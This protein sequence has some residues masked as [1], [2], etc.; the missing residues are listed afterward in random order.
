[1]RAMVEARPGAASMICDSIPTSSSFSATHSAAG[2][3]AWVGF[4]VLM[5]IRSASRSATSPWA[6]IVFSER[7]LIPR[8]YQPPELRWCQRRRRRPLS[9][10]TT[11]TATAQTTQSSIRIAG[12]FLGT[13]PLTKTSVPFDFVGTPGLDDDPG[14]VDVEVGAGWLP[15][16]AE[17]E[18]FEESGGVGGYGRVDVPVAD[19][20]DV[21]CVTSEIPGVLGVIGVWG[22]ED[23][24]TLGAW[25]VETGRSTSMR[26]TPE[27]TEMCRPGAVLGGR[28]DDAAAVGLGVGLRAVGRA[29]A[30]AENQKAANRVRR[31]V[32]VTVAI[33]RERA[34]LIG[35]APPTMTPSPRPLLRVAGGGPAKYTAVHTQPT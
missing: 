27:L 14:P 16:G 13:N 1:M 20:R 33:T 11:A 17:A 5:R 10:T 34:C 25:P 6:V 35:A 15:G 3:S 26:R 30:S 21:D 4:D 32:A 31:P 24:G 9:V 7:A 29:W 18:V 22:A 19:F 23:C 12:A 28:D 2:R 8:S